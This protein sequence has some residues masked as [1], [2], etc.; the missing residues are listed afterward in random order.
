[1]IV[2]GAVQKL[3][4]TYLRGCA[5]PWGPKYCPSIATEVRGTQIGWWCKQSGGPKDLQ[6]LHLW[7]WS[8]LGPC[9]ELEAFP[10]LQVLELWACDW[11]TSHVN[12]EHLTSLKELNIATCRNIWFLPTLPQSIVRFYLDCCDDEFTKSCQTVGHP[13]WQKIEHVPKEVIFYPVLDNL[14]S[15]TVIPCTAL[16]SILYL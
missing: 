11:D 8:Q 9:P 13:N 12:L 1:M 10:H 2:Q 6:K 14:E 4:Q 7:G 5:L 3:K 16:F 15:K